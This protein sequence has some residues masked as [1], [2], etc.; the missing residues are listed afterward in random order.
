MQAHLQ[1][2]AHVVEKAVWKISK[3]EQSWKIQK[4]AKAC[5]FDNYLVIA[6]VSIILDHLSNLICV[7]KSF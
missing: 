3:N 4:M 2:F 6:H 7:Q 5:S 1:K